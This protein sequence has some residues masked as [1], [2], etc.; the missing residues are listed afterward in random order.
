MTEFSFLGELSLQSVDKMISI[1]ESWRGKEAKQVKTGWHQREIYCLL[2]D[3][4]SARTK[5]LEVDIRLLNVFK[6]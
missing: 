4:L 2:W 1:T 6:P 5:E 3:S